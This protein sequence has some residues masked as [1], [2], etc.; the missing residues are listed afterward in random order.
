MAASHRKA[1]LRLALLAA[2]VFA[3]DRALAALLGR[4]LPHSHFRFSLAARGGLPPNVLVLGDSRAV[5]G[6]YAPELA[7]H[8]AVPVLNLGYNGM[9]TAVAEA[10]L[11]DYLERNAAPRVLVLEVT[12]VQQDDRLLDGLM[13]YWST[14]P[15]LGALAEARSPVNRRAAGILHLYAYNGE[16]PLRALFYARRSDQDWINRYRISDALLA[17]VRAQ[18]DFELGARPENLAALGRIAAL[19][20]AR[21]IALR[22]LVAPYLPEYLAHARNWD[23]WIARVRAAAGGARIWDYSRAVSDPAQFADRLHLNDRGGVPFA[24]RLAADGFLAFDEAPPPE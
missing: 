18:P 1:L 19:A 14:G 10:L 6:L 11:R 23:D 20:R 13:C 9:S 24:A 5:N 3:G 17:E 8:V 4:A 7:R 2:C 21:G 16:V 12:N 22:L 15:A